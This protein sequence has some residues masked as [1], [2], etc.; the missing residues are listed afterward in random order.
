M[1]YL[2]LPGGFLGSLLGVTRFGDF[3]GEDFPV[4][5]ERSGVGMC[6]RVYYD[7]EGLGT[8]LSCHLEG[9]KKCYVTICGFVS[10]WGA[11]LGER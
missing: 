2:C 8:L 6:S 4:P 11:F 1:R 5:A 10:E 7:G 3:I 9:N